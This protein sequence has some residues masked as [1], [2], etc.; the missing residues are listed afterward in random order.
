MA[1]VEVRRN[2]FKK[3][4]PPNEDWGDDWTKSFNPDDLLPG[5]VLLD[6]HAHGN[7]EIK[8][9]N[10]R[11][12]LER[13]PLVLDSHEYRTIATAL[14]IEPALVASYL[15]GVFYAHNERTKF[16]SRRVAVA[17]PVIMDGTQFEGNED[18]IPY[19]LLEQELQ[20]ATAIPRLLQEGVVIDIIGLMFKAKVGAM[21]TAL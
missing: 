17:T 6:P 8:D 11:A 9:D 14:G 3:G 13:P 7:S 5:T 18:M 21:E 4:P 19:F 10:L 1:K 15:A 20:L 12:V 2:I 16:G